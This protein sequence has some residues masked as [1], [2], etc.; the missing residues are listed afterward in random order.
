LREPGRGLPERALATAL[1]D[2][3]QGLPTG[4]LTLV[5]ELRQADEFL[6]DLLFEAMLEG[7][8]DDRKVEEAMS[9]ETLARLEGMPSFRAWQEKA[10]TA[11][12]EE[13]RQEGRHEGWQEGR[14][15]GRQE[16]R[17]EGRDEGLLKGR[18]QTLLQFFGAR[19]D[20]VPAHAITEITNCA[21]VAVL[22][23]WLERAFG[24]E[25]AEEIFRS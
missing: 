24:G 14:L 1:C 20:R 17:Q 8:P 13:G 22:D 9:P 15:E 19:R 7:C 10:R 6:A 23:G 21:D 25:S 12:R 3:R 5:T 11:G 4:A 16:G 18:A 2:F